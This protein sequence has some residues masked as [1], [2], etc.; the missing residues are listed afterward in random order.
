MIPRTSQRR[1]R[2]W[3]WRERKANGGGVEGTTVARGG[4]EGT[5]GTRGG[6]EGTTGIREEGEE[7]A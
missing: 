3:D 5:T 6:V 4:V 7:R 1:D 2:K